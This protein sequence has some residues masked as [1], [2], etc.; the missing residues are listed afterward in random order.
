MCVL[1]EDEEVGRGASASALVE[2]GEVSETG[3]CKCVLKGWGGVLLS[4]ASWPSCL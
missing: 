2:G 1:V 4:C 3:W